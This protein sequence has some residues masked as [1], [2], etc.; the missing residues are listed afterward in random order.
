M[1]RYPYIAVFISTLAIL[2]PT[3]LLADDK[4]PSY[5][6]AVK[7]FQAERA[8]SGGPK[9]SEADQATLA[10]AQKDLAARMPTPGL[11][12][13]QHAPDFTLPDA[14]GNQVRLYDFLKQ[15]PVVLA[16]YRGAWCPYC[17]MELHTI[18]ASLEHFRRLGASLIAVTPQT[19]DKSLQQVEK[20]G[21]PFPILSDLDD[22]VM[23]AYKL[24][25]EVPPE[26]SDVYRRNF[27]LDLAEYNG[28]GR[29]VLPVPGTFVID[30]QGTI[31][32]VFANTDYTKRMEPAAIVE[33]LEQMKAND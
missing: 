29:Y 7:R 31:R 15:G 21:Y 9:I 25:F 18:L 33:A 32:A 1:T 11:K 23:A 4:I 13:G 16:F 22:R 12:V 2:G 24:K 19:P 8:S 28:P 3:L 14:H 10:K 30:P 20:D 5:A 6:E 27:S 17:N 26:V